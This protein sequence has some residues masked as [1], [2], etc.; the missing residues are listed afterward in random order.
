MK[1]YEPIYD[2]TADAGIKVIGNS[3]NELIC[4]AI[5]A[6]VNEMVELK[7]IKPK[8]EFIIEITSL[9]FPYSLADI[10][11]KVLYVFE[12]KKT[13][14]VKCK[15]IEISKDGKS[16]KLLLKGEKYNPQKHGRKLLIK[17]ATYHKLS[18]KKEEDKYKAQI[19]F[20]I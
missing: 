6:T 17:A 3:L 9:G 8:E 10:I 7:N 4:N 12:V 1:F 13:I 15:V 14:P 20:D 19:I 16:I 18:L 11:N 5:L 2:I